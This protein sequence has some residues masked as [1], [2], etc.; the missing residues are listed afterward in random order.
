[1]VSL[2]FGF[3]GR[4]NRLQYWLGNVVTG[5]A[6]FVCLM[7]AALIAGPAE[8]EKIDPGAQALKT[9]LV[10]A[11]VWAGTAWM[12]LALQVKRFHDRGRS[13]YFALAPLVPMVVIFTSVSGGVLADAP[14]EQVVPGT[15]LWFFI[16]GCINL[17]FLIDLGTLGGSREANRFGDPPGSGLSPGRSAAGQ[18][19]PAGASS[20][21]KAAQGSSVGGAGAAME[22]AIR[23]QQQAARAPS[24][25]LTPGQTP[26]PAN[27][28]ASST[29]QAGG[30]APS[31]GKRVAR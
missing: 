18:G 11:P 20:E 2:F 25:A 21:H 8:G 19:A 27:F 1:M 30:S 28:K 14:A 17:W 4:I 12:S 6:G 7:L 26:A 16:L 22:M 9:M 29:T 24:P 31:F 3:N 13:G 23:G 10:M 5:V 15:L